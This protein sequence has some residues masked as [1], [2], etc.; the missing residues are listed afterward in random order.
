MLG[1]DV[2]LMNTPSVLANTVGREWL[3]RHHRDHAAD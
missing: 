2:A 3:E 1:T